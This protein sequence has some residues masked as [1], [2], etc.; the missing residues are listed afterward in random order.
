ML[1][2]IYIFYILL[3]NLEWLYLFW[4]IRPIC[5]TLLD[6]LNHLSC[7]VGTCVCVFI[8]DIWKGQ[9]RKRGLWTPTC[10]SMWPSAMCFCW[11]FDPS[12]WDL[13]LNSTQVCGLLDALCN[14]QD[15]SW[16]SWWPQI[17][18]ETSQISPWTRLNW[19]Q[20]ILFKLI[21]ICSPVL[22]STWKCVSAERTQAKVCVPR[23]NL[24]PDVSGSWR[25]YRSIF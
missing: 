21:V 1:E 5:Q 9:W 11:L 14:P 17:I 6:I 13:L 2:Y 23:R 4:Q 22:W 12:S 7:S 10:S 8:T 24:W 3:C 16:K 18:S 19:V 20:I 15:C 25:P